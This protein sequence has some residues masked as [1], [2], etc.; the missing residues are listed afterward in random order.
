M[1][2]Y[3]TVQSDP[4]KI[5]LWI[6]GSAL[7]LTVLLSSFYSVSST[8]RGI[9]A[10]FGKIN[11][12]AVD[13]GLHVKIPFVQSIDKMSIQTVKMEQ[14]S[15]AY[16]KDIQSSTVTYVL[17]FDPVP[18]SVAVLYRNVGNNY[19]AKI[20]T[21]VVEG[22]LKDVIGNYN[23]ADIVSNREEVRKGVEIE[24]SS[25]LPSEYVRNVKF[26]LVNIDYD[27]A[28]EQSIVDK[29]VA[30]QKA[31]TAK[32]N[33][34]RIQEDCY[35]FI[36]HDDLEQW[37]KKSGQRPRPRQCRSRQM[38]SAPIPTSPSMRP[39]KNGTEKCLHTCSA[40]PS[41]SSV[42]Q[43]NPLQRKRSHHVGAPGS[44]AAAACL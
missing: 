35:A 33:T 5:M 31:L 4:K 26:Q 23:A 36:D 1:K 15:M 29:Q 30:E 28:F 34:I 27:D 12:T 32:N 8:Q 17:N 40:I 3:T 43:N 7:A 6:I 25:Q 37:L 24:L 14:T 9:I 18:E 11:P 2:T 44:A 41:H 16:T 10:T 39:Y 21:P 42:Y 38:P 19:I 20:I 13:A 22:V